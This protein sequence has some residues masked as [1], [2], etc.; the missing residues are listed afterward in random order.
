MVRMVRSARRRVVSVSCQC[1]NLGFL[2]YMGKDFLS[3]AERKHIQN[4]RAYVIRHGLKKRYLGIQRHT[5]HILGHQLR[6]ALRVV[7]WRRRQLRCHP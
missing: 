5:L 7:Y 4:R 3:D 1:I 6:R 2:G